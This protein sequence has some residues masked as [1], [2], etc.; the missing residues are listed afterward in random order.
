MYAIKCSEK[1]IDSKFEKRKQSGDGIPS[2]IWLQNLCCPRTPCIRHHPPGRRT[3]ENRWR[4]VHLLQQC[5]EG[6]RL[7][8]QRN[9]GSDKQSRHGNIHFNLKR[10]QTTQEK[11][12]LGSPHLTSPDTPFTASDSGSCPCSFLGSVPLGNLI[13]VHDLNILMNTTPYS[14]SDFSSECWPLFLIS[15]WAFPH[16]AISKILHS[17]SLRSIQYLS[18]HTCFECHVSTTISCAPALEH[19]RPASAHSAAACGATTQEQVHYGWS[20]VGPRS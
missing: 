18:Q 16:C 12:F 17:T 7:L 2:I 8:L 20:R 9:W 4:M 6:K 1:L 3:P 14:S 5:K 10:Q 19:S 11:H 15:Y 13:H